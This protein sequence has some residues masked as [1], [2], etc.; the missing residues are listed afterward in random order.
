MANS[1]EEENSLDIDN[2][3]KILNEVFI[4]I[5]ESLETKENSNLDE[6][7]RFNLVHWMNGY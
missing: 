2:E 1:N 7:T 6:D 5:R 4:S 3:K